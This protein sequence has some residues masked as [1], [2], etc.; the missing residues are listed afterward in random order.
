MLRSMRIETAI[1]SA[2]RLA[3]GGHRV[4]TPQPQG[5]LYS[6]RFQAEGAREAKAVEIAAEDAH[7][8][9]AIA[10]R[11]A[12]RCPAEWWRDGQKLC[13]FSH[14]GDEVWEISPAA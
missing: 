12:R 3:F 8:A 14:A 1:R 4:F 7:G 9:F 13:S 5:G 6:L 11:E 10:H 2:T